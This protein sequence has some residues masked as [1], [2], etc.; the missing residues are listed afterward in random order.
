MADGS[1]KPIE[2]VKTGDK[3]VA[4]DP[5]T[6]RN[7]VQTVADTLSSKGTK[8]LVTIT[9]D[10]D[11][12]K[13]SATGTLSAT[14]NHPFWLPHEHRWAKAGELKPGTWLCTSTGTWVRVT[15]IKAWT[16]HAQRVHNLTTTGTYTYHVR[17]G[18]AAVLV[19][20]EEG[21]ARFEV[22]CDGTVTDT[23]TEMPT[24]R[25]RRQGQYG[26]AQTDSPNGQAAR[27][28]GAG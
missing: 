23:E 1:T 15:A 17:A 22:G 18:S 7:S 2:K 3:V 20:N 16:A 26:G 12:A 8:H 6:G 21:S 19:H 25:Y 14:D 24:E 11:G 28:A 10:N 5:N 4:T 9:I 13:G 27:A